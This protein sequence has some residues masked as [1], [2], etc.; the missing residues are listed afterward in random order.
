MTELLKSVRLRSLIFTELTNISVSI[1]S[2]GILGSGTVSEPIPSILTI[3]L[4]FSGWM[5]KS[6]WSPQGEY[7]DM[8]LR[9]TLRTEEYRL[10]S[11]DGTLSVMDVRSKKSVPVAQS[12]DQ[13]DELLSIVSIKGFVYLVLYRVTWGSTKICENLVDPSSCTL[14]DLGLGMPCGSG[15]I[16]KDILAWIVATWISISTR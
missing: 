2:F 7:V 5:I 3:S 12:E 10:Y 11:G 14:R 15:G 1:C 16:P 13:E 8:Q 9:R 4:I 6:N